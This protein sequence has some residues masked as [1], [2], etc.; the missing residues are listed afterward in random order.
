MPSP[1]QK[2]SGIDTTQY[3]YEVATGKMFHGLTLLWVGYSGKGVG[4]NNSL[5]EMIPDIGPCPRGQFVFG[6]AKDDPKMGP[7]A[8]PILPQP[9]T[10]MFGRSGIYLHGDNSEHDN[11]ASEGCIIKSPIILRE[12]FNEG[13]QLTVV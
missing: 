6:K 7:C 4:L 11:T 5:Y 13:D 1:L 2:P 3:I 10:Q 8:I 9:G 12:R